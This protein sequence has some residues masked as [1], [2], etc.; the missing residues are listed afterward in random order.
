MSED[1]D[2]I[3]YCT[4]GKIFFRQTNCGIAP[5]HGLLLQSALTIMDSIS[6]EWIRSRRCTE[7]IALTV[8]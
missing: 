6:F 3:G 5:L 7:A 4:A 1:H 2:R 8:T